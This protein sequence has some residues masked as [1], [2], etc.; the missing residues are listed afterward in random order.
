MVEVTDAPSQSATV[1]VTLLV[2]PAI[3]AI[4]TKNPAPATANA[5]YAS[6]LAAS[7]GTPP[8]AWTLKTGTLPVGVTLASNGALSGTPPAGGSA[9][10]TV[11]VTDSGA[12]AQTASASLS[13]TVSVAALSVVTAAVG[14]ATVN[15][16]YSAVLA[17]TGGQGSYSWSLQSGVLPPGL[18][19]S[20]TG[21]L[22]GTPTAAGI[23]TFM[24]T[25]RDK[26]APQQSA[27][28]TINVVVAATGSTSAPHRAPS[29]S[30]AALPV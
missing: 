14:T 23:T 9:T 21:N 29:R 10:F 27:S 11:E 22:S 28:Q 5:A 13:L 2:S 6:S 7:G 18:S 30:A 4:A 1:A 16:N 25:V 26:S 20:S 19:L 17:A 24:A 12:L 3:L 8:Y 15:S